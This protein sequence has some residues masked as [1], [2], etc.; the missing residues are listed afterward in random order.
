MAVKID[1]LAE[2]A[3]LYKGTCVCMTYKYIIAHI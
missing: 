1:F 2:N 3:E